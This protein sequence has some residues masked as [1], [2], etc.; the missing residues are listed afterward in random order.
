M[1][2]SN[3]VERFA[4]AQLILFIESALGSLLSSSP[5]LELEREASISLVSITLLV[6][7]SP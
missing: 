4:Q 5:Q 1:I 3:T 7:I 2:A 6:A